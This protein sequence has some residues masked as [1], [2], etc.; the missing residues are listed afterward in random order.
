MMTSKVV[1]KKKGETKVPSSLKQAQRQAISE[2]PLGHLESKEATLGKVKS[3]LNKNKDLFMTSMD[4]YGKCKVQEF[5]VDMKGHPPILVRPFRK[6][7]KERELENK[8]TE[9]YIK[10]GV[11]GKSMSPWGFPVVLAAKKDGTVRFCVDYRKANEVLGKPKYP[12]PRIDD[13]VDSMSG[14]QIFS[15]IDLKAA[16]WQIKIR[17]ADKDKLAF[18]TSEGCFS[19]NVMPFGV[20]TAPACFQQTM[21]LVLAGIKWNYALVYL[22]DII[23][24][25][26]T[27]E[28]H[29]SHLEEVF[30]RLRKAGLKCN[31]EKC[32]FMKD[33]V[34]FLG[35]IIS[36][37]GI[38]PNQQKVQAVREI[39]PPTT[40]TEVK[41]FL[42]M[43]GYYRK[44][45]KNFSS[46]AEP[47]TELTKLGVEFYWSHE[48]QQA[49]DHLKKALT[50]SPILAH[51]GPTLQNRLKSTRMHQ[52]SA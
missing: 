9:E 7:P 20:S 52:E 41:S 50:T 44:F 16:Y 11:A 39:K 29:L 8:M 42:G 27:E 36:A 38:A 43:A 30:K 33:K 1:V 6:S 46:I 49:F 5:E 14:A 28:E 13:D 35:H 15:T 10:S 21:D 19:W 18:R 40:V 12:L 26:K 22:D 24:Y 37:E 4:Q 25:S 23:V 48:C 17:E 32:E 2:V 3:L 34:A 51:P 45:I 31:A 47:I